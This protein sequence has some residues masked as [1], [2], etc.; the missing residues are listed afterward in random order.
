MAIAFA[1]PCSANWAE[2]SG[3]ARARFCALCQ[4]H[5][6]DLSRMTRAEVDDLLVRTEGKACGRFFT[7]ADGTVLT[8]DCPVGLR[9]R[10]QRARR[11]VHAG[12][13]ALLTACLALLA[14]F[15]L[16]EECVDAPPEPTAVERLPP[17]ARPE[18]PTPPP[19]PPLPDAPRRPNTGRTTLQTLITGERHA[20]MGRIHTIGI[21]QVVKGSKR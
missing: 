2:M 8:A 16:G 1:S 17:L 3:D 7:R 5:V 15:G 20:V 14:T 13:T 19:I 4:K 21:I 9:E 18:I 10:L 12:A 11:R 6:Y